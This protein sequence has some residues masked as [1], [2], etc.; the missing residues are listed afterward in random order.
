MIRGFVTALAALFT[1]ASATAEEGM[2]T[3]DQLPGLSNELGAAGLEL[4]PETLTDLTAFPM[5]AVVSLGGCTGAFVSG[6]GLVVTNHHCARGSVQY[7]ASTGR[8]YLQDGFLADDLSQELPAAPGTRVFVTVSVLDVTGVIERDLPANLSGRALFQEIE[9]RKKALIA[10]CER[11]P[12]H[13]CQVASFF[14][15]AQYKLIDRLEL[16]DIRLVYAPAD[17]IGSYGGDIDNWQWPRHTGDFAFYRAYVSPT[18]QPADFD[19]AA[20]VPFVP[21]H[22]LKVSASGLADGDFVM[23][24]GYPGRTRRYARLT[25]VQ[26]EF[27]WF[28]PSFS[29]LMQQWIRTIERAAPEGS[30]ARIRYE[31]RLQGLNNYLKNVGG[32]LAGAEETGLVERRRQRETDL[33]TWVSAQPNGA[34][35]QADIAAVD[36]IAGQI[37][38]A[39]RRDFWYDQVRRPQL[40]DAAR[41]LY[42]LA[43]EKTKPNAQREP[44]YQNRDL[45][46][47]QQSLERVQRRFHPGVDREEWKLFLR[48]YMDQPASSRV[49]AFDRA[50]GLADTYD[51]AAT[52]AILD[53]FYNDTTLDDLQTRIDLMSAS[54]G[55]LARNPDPFIQL[56]V[57]LYQT[58]IAREDVE[59]ALD[60]RMMAARP[61]YMRAIIDYQ[62][63]QGREAY[64]DANS[65]LR[66]TF[67]HVMGGSP[68]DGLLYAAFTSLNGLVEKE[69]G[70]APFA[71]PDALL[72]QIRAGTI[73]SYASEALGTVPVNFLTDLDSTGGNSGSPTLNAN[74]ELVGLLFDGT[75]ESVNSDWDFDPVNTRTIHVDTR[76]MLWVMDFV[77]GASGLLAEMD[78]VG[79]PDRAQRA[80]APAQQP[81]IIPASAPPTPAPQTVTEPTPVSLEAVEASPTGQN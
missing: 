61:G 40:L 12:G 38:A 25:E 69:T 6:K 79:L 5:G 58:D 78:I 81:T 33:N 24:A 54:A 48:G 13:R 60:G 65:T 29:S 53:R 74:G 42:R 35:Y 36:R 37:A 20:N 51:E 30:D 19:P 50:M 21:A 46:L 44:G 34:T 49:E 32:Q 27:S 9:T 23:A 22:H 16:R 64:P 10:E 72:A 39:E 73:G 71:S 28:Y 77:D 80:P 59:E 15:G 57:A 55:Q 26:H 75:L 70:E 62:A 3:P 31:A 4:A 52:N 17:A 7:N 1:L 41:K 43:Q 76:Y 2:W 11:Q 66:V 18:G 68:A 8:N 14:G 45:A 47:L 67:G 63:A 56:A